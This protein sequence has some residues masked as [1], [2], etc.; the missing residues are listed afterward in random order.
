MLISNL[1]DILNVWPSIWQG[2]RFLRTHEQS[3]I[4]N[5]DKTS[6]EL[7]YPPYVQSFLDVVQIAPNILGSCQFTDISFKQLQLNGSHDPRT[8]EQINEL[9]LF[10]QAQMRCEKIPSPFLTNIILTKENG[11]FFIIAFE[12]HI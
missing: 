12:M 2:K 4:T 10:Y 9:L 11:K 7:I 3:F 5:W 6:V 1:P 8:G